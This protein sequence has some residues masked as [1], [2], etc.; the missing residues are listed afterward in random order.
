MPRLRE[1]K[2]NVA[3]FRDIVETARQTDKLLLFFS[4]GSVS[5]P[6]YWR[7]LI[8]EHPIPFMLE[9]RKGFRALNALI[10]YYRFREAR[11][12]KAAK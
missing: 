2:D 1:S 6:E 11:Q 5:L 12:K 7:Q 8:G 3:R 9:Y 10:D 4:R